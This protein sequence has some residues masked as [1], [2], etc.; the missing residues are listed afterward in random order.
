VTSEAE[1]IAA[2]QGGDLGGLPTLV[3]LHQ[4]RAR[5][6]AYGI[7]WNAA[8]AEDVAADAFVRVVERIAQYDTSR[9]FWPWLLAIVTNL[10]LRSLRPYRRLVFGLESDFL[11]GSLAADGPDPAAIAERTELRR[12]LLSAMARLSRQ[13][14]AVVVLRFFE[15][16]DVRSIA[17]VLDCPEGTVKSTLHR[18]L[19]HLG[20]RLGRG[21]EGRAIFEY[22]PAGGSS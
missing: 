15:D 2:L 19:V 20:V 11:L 7:T 17:E 13:E 16:L 12:L 14:R 9:P 5:R 1:A 8:D 6:V 22:L 4:L 3:E 21:A 18:A 10:A